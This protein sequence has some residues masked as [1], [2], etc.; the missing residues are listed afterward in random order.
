MVAVVDPIDS[1]FRLDSDLHDYLNAQVENLQI[2][3]EKKYYSG[4]DL[5]TA[6]TSSES[7]QNLTLTCDTYIHRNI[8][9]GI[10]EHKD[11]EICLQNSESIHEFTL[12]IDNQC[13]IK[14]WGRG[15]RN[16][17]YFD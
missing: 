15:Y 10:C 6:D 11:N 16:L 4:Y 2:D 13:P 3:Y 14:C 8:I 17:Q 5:E 9:C 12:D 7:V 1:N